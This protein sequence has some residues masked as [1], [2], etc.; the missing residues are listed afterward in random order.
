MGFDIFASL[1]ERFMDTIADLDLKLV[2]TILSK[3]KNRAKLTL[4]SSLKDF[5]SEHL[6]NYQPSLQ[7]VPITPGYQFK[8]PF[9]QNMRQTKDVGNFYQNAEPKPESSFTKSVN[10]LEKVGHCI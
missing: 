4:V 2:K 1:V 8:H 7:Y 5:K 6:R 10:F 9:V 3:N